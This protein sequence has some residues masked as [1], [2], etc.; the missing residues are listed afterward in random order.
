MQYNTY[1]T[2]GANS[3]VNSPV[4]T[5]FGV[6]TTAGHA[7]YVAVTISRFANLYSFTLQDTQGNTFIQLDQENDLTPGWQTV[8]HFYAANIRGDTAAPD[9]VYMHFGFPGTPDGWEDYVGMV[10][11]EIGGVSAAPL[12]GHS[13]GIQDNLAAGNN[14]VGSAAIEVPASNPALQLAIAM[15]TT[16]ATAGNW[17]PVIGAGFGLDTQFWSWGLGYND[18]T[19]ESRTI[20]TSGA[21]APTFSAVGQPATL[22]PSGVDSFITV[23]AVFN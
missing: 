7:L 1:Q 11:T 4:H 18:A 2:I 8:A 14:N 13:A 5:Q 21:A 12:V 22:D 9:I 3:G 20:N 16:G 10:I 17:S 23:S 6:K 15:D 19:L